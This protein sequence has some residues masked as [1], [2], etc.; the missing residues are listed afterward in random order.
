MTIDR[1]AYNALVNDSGGNVDGSSWDK[2]AIKNVLLDPIDA[3]ITAGAGAVVQTTTSTGTVNDFALTSGAGFL[4][5]NNATAL[6]L[7]GLAAGTDGQRVTIVS[8]GAGSVTLT[9]QAAG[10]TA[11]NRIITGTGGALTLPAG[12]GG[13]TLLYDATTARWRVNPVPPTGQIAFPA[14]QV[15]S[16]DVNVLDDY[17]EGTWTPTIGGSGG[18][19]GQVYSYQ[20]GNYIKIGKLVMAFF[21]VG[22]STLGTITT[23]VQIKGLPFTS[24]TST[25]AVS[26]ICWHATTTAYVFM[27]SSVAASD[28][29]ATILGMTAAGTT[30]LA[31]PI[32]QANLSATT[33]FRGTC[34]YRA[35]A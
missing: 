20:I 21:D 29:A 19:S 28:N 18:Q 13:V 4:R 10:S 31:V 16:S 33:I 26:N 22:L 3:A 6:T 23:N 1:T 34:M 17:E 5:A 11:A 24:D 8:I 32:A 35:S 9:D 30:S 15:P 27:L 2:N 25:I 14:T 7:T 12:S